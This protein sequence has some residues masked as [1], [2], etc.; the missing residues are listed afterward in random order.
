MLQVIF[1][2]C[3][4][5]Q[6]VLQT[7]AGV[8]KICMNLLI[9]DDTALSLARNV[10]ILSIISSPEFDPSDMDNIEYLWDIWYKT[11]YTF[12]CYTTKFFKTFLK[13]R[14]NTMWPEKTKVRFILDIEALLSSGS[15]MPANIAPLPLMTLQNLRVIWADWLLA[16]NG[17]LSNT[18][19]VV[20]IF[21]NRSVF[22]VV[23]SGK[24]VI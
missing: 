3:S 10:A 6:P 4:D 11:S 24:N 5:L 9:N 17:S 20:N 14:Y 7:V 18:D 13:I 1:L 21:C 12:T 22:K 8:K 19:N 16:I 2:N 15:Q 23:F